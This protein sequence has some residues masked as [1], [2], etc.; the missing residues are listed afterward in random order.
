MKP[1]YQRR[2]TESHRS[3]LQIV[4]RTASHFTATGLIQTPLTLAGATALAFK[5]LPEGWIKIHFIY[6]T[7]K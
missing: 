4:S 6:K 3:Y 2:P 5:Q 1:G 7:I